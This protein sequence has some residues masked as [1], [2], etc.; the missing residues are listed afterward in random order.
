MQS[1][2]EVE[3][4][5]WAISI[6]V[7]PGAHKVTGLDVIA[8]ASEPAHATCWDVRVF[9]KGCRFADNPAFMFALFLFL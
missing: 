1:S 4:M 3:R 5:G 7:A 6:T 9:M 8:L 2:T